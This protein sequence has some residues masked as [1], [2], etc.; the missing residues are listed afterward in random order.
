MMIEKGTVEAA[1]GGKARIK[2]DRTSACGECGHKG[3]CHSLGGTS[4]MIVVVDNPVGARPGDFVEIRFETKSFLVGSF[5][6]YFVPIVGFLIGV[7]FGQSMGPSL[8]IGPDGGA[9]LGGLI[10]LAAFG[11]GSWAVGRRLGEK[12]KY[13]PTISRILTL[14][15]FTASP[16][17]ACEAPPQA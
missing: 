13:Q 15:E 12:P 11:L 7:V 3:A 1:A 5:L 14:E 9:I 6:L 8:G 10:L 16:L 17:T 2:T 4:E